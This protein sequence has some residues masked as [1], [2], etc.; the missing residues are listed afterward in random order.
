MKVILIL[1]HLSSHPDRHLAHLGPIAVPQRLPS[2]HGF[3]HSHAQAVALEAGRHVRVAGV[4]DERG[5]W[6]HCQADALGIIAVHLGRDS[7]PIDANLE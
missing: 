1:K 5:Y 4:V 7:D 6:K 2:F 3:E